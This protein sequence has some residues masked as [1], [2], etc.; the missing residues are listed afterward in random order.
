M[1]KYLFSILFSLFFASGSWAQEAPSVSG[2]VGGE[3][4]AEMLAKQPDYNLKFVF[5]LM[6]GDYV[7]DVAVKI[8]DSTG[9]VVLEKTSDGPILMT[10]L[11]AGRYDATATYEGVTQ[12]RKFA[13]GAKGLRT[14][15][16]RWKRSAADG[17]PLL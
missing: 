1:R 7:A 3:S 2:G 8:T 17:E 11:P 12:T 14:E 13:L 10:R 6:E 5:T 9:K 16:L 15:Q 4:S